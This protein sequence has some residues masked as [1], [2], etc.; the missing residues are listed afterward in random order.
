MSDLFHEQVPSAFIAAMFDVMRRTPQHTYQVLT[1]RHARMRSLARTGVFGEGWPLPN[2]WL[3]VSVEDQHW[4][5]IRIPALCETP[6]AVRFLS[7]EPLL[8]AVKIPFA[9]ETDRCNCGAGPQG[10]YGMHE[11]HCGVEPGRAWNVSW[12]IVGGESGP[13]ARPMEVDWARSLVRQ[14]QDWQVPVFVT[15]LGSV[16]GRELGAGPKGGDWSAWPDDL[17]I[18]EF[19]RVPEA[20]TS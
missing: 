17:K 2:V 3:G 15:Q 14:C 1:K 18:R 10:Y 4:A 5:D 13:G 7:C 19:P 12:V 11:R 6:A 20:V 9:E 16:L 8:G